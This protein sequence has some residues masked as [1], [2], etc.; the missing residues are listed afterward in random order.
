MPFGTPQ[1]TGETIYDGIDLGKK[2]GMIKGFGIGFGKNK[3]MKERD[4]FEVYIPA[5]ELALSNDSHNLVFHVRSPEFYIDKK[6]LQDVDTFIENH[7]HYSHFFDMVAYFFD[8]KSHYFES[9]NGENI[10]SYKRKILELINI[11]REKFNL[12]K[13]LS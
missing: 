1:T 7:S 11:Y 5:L 3:I 4:F 6:H 13:R 10:D 9:I 2:V 12:D 8:A